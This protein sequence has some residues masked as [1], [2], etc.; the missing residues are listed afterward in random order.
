MIKIIPILL[1][2]VI[3]YVV[4]LA[5]SQVDFS[6]M[7]A[8]ALEQQV[9]IGAVVHKALID[10]NEEGTEAAAATAVIME[11]GAAMPP[12]DYAQLFLDSPF[13]YAIVD[14]ERGV[15]VFLGTYETGL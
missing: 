1:G 9:H 4:A 5:T 15:P 3:P 2:V 12:Q 6:G 14:L 8:D 13:V 7:A 11:A 10:V